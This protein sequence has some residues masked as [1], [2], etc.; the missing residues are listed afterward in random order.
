MA[1]WSEAE[2]ERRNDA[3][4]GELTR[5]EHHIGMA[6]RE[7][8]SG[9]ELAT[10]AAMRHLDMANELLGWALEKY[11]APT[12]VQDDVGDACSYREQREAAE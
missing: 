10:H 12:P 6:K 2:I 1:Q 4:K 7:I 11:R 5:V 8:D 9:T 3:L